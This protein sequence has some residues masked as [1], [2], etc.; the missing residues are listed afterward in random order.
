MI[1]LLWLDFEDHGARHH[2]IAFGAN[3]LFVFAPRTFEGEQIV[4]GLVVRFNANHAQYRATPRARR[5][6]NKLRWTKCK[7]RARHNRLR[8]NVT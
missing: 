2:L 7:M 8:F 3:E 4:I 5:T 1:P 6:V